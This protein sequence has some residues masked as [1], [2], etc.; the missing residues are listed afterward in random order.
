MAREPRAR[1]AAER[2]AGARAAVER[3]AGAAA[4][5]LQLQRCGYG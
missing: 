4:M 3:A 5:G 2:A 1:A